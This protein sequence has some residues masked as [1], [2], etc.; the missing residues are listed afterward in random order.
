M[1]LV[2]ISVLTIAESIRAITVLVN[3]RLT[4]MLASDVVLVSDG[5]GEVN[6]VS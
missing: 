2:L 3:C 5:G 6:A 1:D 4:K